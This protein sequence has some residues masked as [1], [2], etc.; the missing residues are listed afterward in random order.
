MILS[1]I[2]KY[3]QARGRASLADIAARFDMDKSAVSGVMASLARR[4]RV[5]RLDCGAC[6]SSGSCSLAGE[7]VYVWNGRGK[8]AEVTGAGETPECAE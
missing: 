7:P 8:V 2:S 3:L 6:A 1:D 4:G 5:A